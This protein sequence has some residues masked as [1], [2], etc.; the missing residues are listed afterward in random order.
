M[1][2]WNSLLSLAFV[3]VFSGCE[4]DDKL[5]VHNATPTAVITSHADGSSVPEASTVLF[6][7]VVTD[8]TN[9]PEE[10]NARWMVNGEE[11]CAEAPPE[12]DGTTAC[13]VEI[14][15][16]STV[17]VRLEVRDPRN[18]TA[19]DEI[20]LSIEE[21]E[22]PAVSL[23]QPTGSDT[24]LEDEPISFAAAVTDAEDTSA[25]LEIWFES[26]LDGRIE[27]SG[28]PDSGG[29]ISGSINLTAGDH[30]LTLWAQD[31]DGKT[32]SSSVTLTVESTTDNPPTVTLTSPVTGDPYYS[33]RL[34]TLSAEAHD[35]ED[36][37]AEEDG[38]S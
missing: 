24:Y 29:G 13:E 38:L 2:T 26:S 14:T 5:S 35:E 18:A 23:L 17:G 3:A 20:E 25:E 6:V 7:G 34:I 8:E 36:D 31:T 32:G 9:P 1:R 12:S 11:A 21:T 4:S 19:T 15:A 28:T 22:P 10:L 16:I 37:D 27:I 33:D 30:D